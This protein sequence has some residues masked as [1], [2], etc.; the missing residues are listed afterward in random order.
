MLLLTAFDVLS[1]ILPSPPSTRSQKSFRPV[2]SRP[3]YVCVT[4]QRNFLIVCLLQIVSEKTAH[5]LLT[6]S[7]TVLHCQ[8]RHISGIAVF[9]ELVTNVKERKLESL[10]CRLHHCG[11][12]RKW[13]YVMKSLAVRQH[14]P[15]V[16]SCR[17]MAFLGSWTRAAP[18][19]VNIKEPRRLS[20][21]RSPSSVD[22]D[23]RAG[24][25][26]RPHCDR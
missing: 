19:S 26:A 16:T 3:A 23:G 15:S 7:V 13:K 20:S 1:A 14:D 22:L 8:M 17:P 2:L 4:K 18:Q 11:G 9:Y 12:F 21:L 5:C 10:C 24:P 25:G 6:S